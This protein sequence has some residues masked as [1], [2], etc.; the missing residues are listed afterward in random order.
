[1][2]R[3]NHIVKTLERLKR[4][5]PEKAAAI[6]QVLDNPAM[7]SQAHTRIAAEVPVQ[8][9]GSGTA[10]PILD[11]LWAHKELILQIIMTIVALFASGT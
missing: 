9:S 11:W 4:H 1:M 5:N 6:Q 10:H 2:I 8:E 7:L 3:R